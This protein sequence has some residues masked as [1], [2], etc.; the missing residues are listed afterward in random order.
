MKGK[1]RGIPAKQK[2]IT[3]LKTR[4]KH[5]ELL[6]FSF[7]LFCQ[8]LPLQVGNTLALV[9]KMYVIMQ[10]EYDNYQKQDITSNESRE[11]GN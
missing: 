7:A 2:K 11:A 5:N 9:V 6:P 1:G 3:A 8:I 4:Q 10:N